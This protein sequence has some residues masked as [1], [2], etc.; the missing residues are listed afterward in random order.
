ME[1]ATC[2]ACGKDRPRSE[3]VRDRSKASGY[4]S[5]CKECDRAKGRVYYAQN[6]EAKLRACK[7]R[8][9]TRP[10][11]VYPPRPCETCE[12]TYQPH[13]HD[14]RFCSAG[15]HRHRREDRDTPVICQTCGATV[16]KLAREASKYE[17]HFCS[18][19][20]AGKSPHKKR[21]PPSVRPGHELVG[22][23]P[24]TVTISG[25]CC[26]LS[27]KPEIGRRIGGL[28]AHCGN[29]FVSRGLWPTIYC[30]QRCGRR[31]GSQ[32]R[33]ERNKANR[34]SGPRVY[35]RKIHD[36]DGWRCQLCGNPVRRDKRVPHPKAPTLDHIVP[37]SLGG[38]WSYENLQTAHFSCNSR[39]GNRGHASHRPDQL[40]LL[41]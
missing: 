12:Q 34:R 31:A 2:P 29:P 4:A 33:K 32:A 28:C 38:A 7:K 13:R 19:S 18:K 39:K 30:S 6:R 17:H 26:L 5:R 37:A 23:L 9:T 8:K 15:C 41:G 40:L 1:H 14:Q 21:P 20:C 10:K 16:L 35:R 36:R 22:P 24:R 25:P 11:K 3:F 27:D